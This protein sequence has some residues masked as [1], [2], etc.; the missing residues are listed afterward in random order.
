M[1]TMISAMALLL[2]TSSCAGDLAG[3]A[4]EGTIT[5]AA[6]VEPENWLNLEARFCTEDRGFCDYVT[7]PTSEVS[8]PLEY[9][10]SHGTTA[11]RTDE[12]W[13]VRAWLTNREGHDV[14]EAEGDEPSGSTSVHFDCRADCLERDVNV[15]IVTSE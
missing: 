1:R 7:Y 10:L 14:E 9:S 13:I 3:P 12:T 2:L 8:F 5:L 15:E 11:G 4:V 6:E